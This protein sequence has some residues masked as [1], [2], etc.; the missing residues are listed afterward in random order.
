M[1]EEKIRF[2]GRYLGISERD[3][4]EFATRT[5]ASSVAVLVPVT[6]QDQIVLVEQFRIPVNA[7]VL[8]LPAG[9]VGDA[10]NAGEST[11]TAAERELVEETGYAAASMTLLLTC[12]S[13]PG[14]SDEIITFYLAE[15]LERVGPG[16]GDGSEDI[17][18]H[19]VP[20]ASASEWLG[21]RM[22]TG[23]LLDPKIYSAL[24]WLERRS[25]GL[26]PV[27]LR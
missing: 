19:L 17:E 4:W 13:S 26:G 16:G 25:R 10:E 2:R 7:R 18:V 1:G 24:H 8:E 12:P 5:N 3:D 6:E 11:R 23:V 9:L 20:V 15:N 21:Q 22:A 14:M 27:P